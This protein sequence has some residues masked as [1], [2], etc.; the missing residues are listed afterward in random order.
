[1]YTVLYVPGPEVGVTNKQVFHDSFK[2]T[3]TSHE[4]LRRIRKGFN[5]SRLMNGEGGKG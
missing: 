2:L 1:M 3:E 4:R 5:K